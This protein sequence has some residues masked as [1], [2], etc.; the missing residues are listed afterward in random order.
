MGGCGGS[1][2][3][4]SIYYISSPAATYPYSVGPGVAANT[5]ATNS[6]FSTTPVIA[7]G[8]IAGNNGAGAA[9][10]VGGACSGGTVNINGGD[11]QGG[12]V[13]VASTGPGG[14][15]GNGGAS[16][17]GGGGAGG[18]GGGGTVGAGV[19][20]GSGGGGAGGGNSPPTAGASA[21]GFILVEEFY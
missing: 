5:P 21:G 17:W 8:G 4:T 12:T 6:Y 1:A 15:G 18:S 9:K 14:A 16:Y 13:G 3:G 19:A 2:G 20:Y 11:G 7:N 10:T